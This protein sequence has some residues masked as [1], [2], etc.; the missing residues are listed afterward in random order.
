MD[1]IKVYSELRSRYVPEYMVKDYIEIV[2]NHI[3]DYIDIS[4]MRFGPTAA[5]VTKDFIEQGY[6][7]ITDDPKIQ[8]IISDI[9]ADK[10]YN[11]ALEVNVIPIP[12]YVFNIYDIIAIKDYADSLEVGYTYSLLKTSNGEDVDRNLMIILILARPDITFYLPR[13]I[14]L[15][16]INEIHKKLPL[17][18]YKQKGK[19]LIWYNGNAA[20]AEY[21]D[22]GFKVDEEVIASTEEDIAAAME[23]YIV[24]PMSI[25]DED[26]WDDNSIIHK[27][28]KFAQNNQSSSQYN[29]VINGEYK[30]LYE[31]LFERYVQ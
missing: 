14:Y 31:E 2:R 3:G 16:I 25:F 9:K 28:L 17:D 5:D 19:Y 15:S 8:K 11:Q 20:Y 27:F 24:I 23:Q 30:T 29:R 13:T 7:F 4:G 21:T 22:A 10:E 18:V 1:S 6:T 26:I 12:S